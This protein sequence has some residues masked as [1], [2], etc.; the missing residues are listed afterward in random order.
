[1]S[2]VF[3]DYLGEHLD[4]LFNLPGRYDELSE[5]MKKRLAADFDGY[6]LELK[7]LYIN[8]ITPP[9][10]VQQAIDDRGRLGVFD[11]L[12][13]LMKMKAAMALEKAAEGQGEAGAGVGMGMG[14]MMP[15]M[16]HEAARE[17]GS[18]KPEPPA[19]KCGDCGK[20][21]PGDS[22]FCPYCGAQILVLTKC[23]KCAKNLPPGAKFCPRCGEPVKE[24]A[25]P[26]ICPHCKTENLATSV[27]CN[28][29]GNKI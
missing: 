7:N 10:D 13:K 4:T 12:N 18:S 9:P 19:A 24:K 6:G 2:P 21:V 8:S 20:D 17:A 5:G 29:C 27:F 3:N 16:F 11:D 22:R 23:A 28:Q 26:K 15:A 25:D 14:L 1:M